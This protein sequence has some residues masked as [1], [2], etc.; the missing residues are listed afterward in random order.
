V[1]QPASA[2]HQFLLSSF[3]GHAPAAADPAVNTSL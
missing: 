3:R 2:R 1:N